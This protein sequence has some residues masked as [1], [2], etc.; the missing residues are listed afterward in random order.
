[1]RFEF[2]TAGRIVFGAGTLR[3]AGDIAAG[4]GR[5]PLVATGSTGQRAEP[6][7]ALL[8]ER[9]LD[10]VT[11]AV[12]REPDVETVRAAT[13]TALQEGCDSVIGI[14]GGAVVDTAKAVAILATNAGDVTDY[15]EI[16]GHG[17]ALTEPSLPLVA[18]PTTAGTGS[19]VARNSV[20]ASRE[21]GVKVS[22]RSPR[23]L[24]SAAV[25][26]PELTYTLPPD[27]TAATGV[28]ALTQ[29]I[30]PFVCKRANPLTD[31]VCQEGIR[32]AAR[33]LRRAF[34][35]AQKASV[36]AEAREDMAVASLFGGL[37]LANAG[38]GAVHGLAGPLG[39][40][41][42]APHGALCASLLPHV[43]ETNLEALRD[44]APKST[45][46]TRYAR[47]AQLLTGHEEATADDAAA[48]LKKLVLDL[49]IPGLATY[50]VG[51]AVIAE[52]VDKAA[53]ANSMKANPLEL[54]RDELATIVEHAL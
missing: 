48:W 27:I 31:G 15:L 30:E 50:G 54:T 43:V 22:L 19:E 33:S 9:G 32:R 36:D 37:A 8:R 45:A 41:I 16:I 17:R 35:A 40:M 5:R 18:I 51:P 1:M 2:A 42:D 49:A 12:T 3:E 26:D 38:L 34:R 11:V 46:L 28:D 53:R 20:I 21:H 24:P 47:V 7:L 14:G 13:A 39:G 44:R 52:L 10:P 4:L 25:V 6:L 23:M 29:L